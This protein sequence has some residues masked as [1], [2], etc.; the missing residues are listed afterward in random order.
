MAC[1]PPLCNGTGGW[2][3]C[4][5]QCCPPV[6]CCTQVNQ[7]WEC[8][9]G[10]GAW[11]GPPPNNGCDCTPVTAPLWSGLNLTEGLDIPM[12]NF[13]YGMATDEDNGFVWALVGCSV[14]C[15]TVSVTITTSGCC[16]QVS[17]NS[18]TVVGSGTISAS[19][20]IGP[21]DCGPLTA[22]VNGS[23]GSAYLTDCTGV[24]ITLGVTNGACCSC[25]LISTSCGATLFAPRI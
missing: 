23:P 11:E 21:G 15:A 20:G 13:N 25:C 2:C 9:T 4:N 7:T 10:T 24:S 6:G 12:P 14:P 1:T 17:G 19:V 18:I 16:L 22:Y 3:G 8:G 5:C